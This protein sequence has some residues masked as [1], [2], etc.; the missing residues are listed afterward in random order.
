MT[1]RLI[2]GLEEI[3]RSLY[4][5]V[6]TAVNGIALLDWV[7]E[8]HRV[9]SVW[10]HGGGA[11]LRIGSS[12]H[13]VVPVTTSHQVDELVAV[14]EQVLVQGAWHE[15][16]SL[17]QR[18]GV[19]EPLTWRLGSGIRGVHSLPSAARPATEGVRVRRQG[20]RWGPPQE[21]SPESED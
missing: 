20:A 11:D 9:L 13:T 10:V 7:P 14:L 6:F 1:T 12:I 17:H 18:T 3:G 19:L 16:F 21:E 4:L 15:T 2:D 5:Q 8:E